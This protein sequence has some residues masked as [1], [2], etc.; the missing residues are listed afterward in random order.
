MG[1]EILGTKVEWAIM[2]IIVLLALSAPFVFTYFAVRE[3]KKSMHYLGNDGKAIHYPACASVW[4]PKWDLKA[5]CDCG[6]S[7]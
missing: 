6:A 5:K 4:G 2:L 1:C 7:R 3:M